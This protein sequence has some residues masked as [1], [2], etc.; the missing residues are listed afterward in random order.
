MLEVAKNIVTI[1][2]NNVIASCYFQILLRK[3]ILMGHNTELVGHV[4]QCA[5]PWLLLCMAVSV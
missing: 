1:Y 5:P 3:N 4:P 2:F